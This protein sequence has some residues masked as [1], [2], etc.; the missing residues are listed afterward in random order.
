MTEPK[1]TKPKTTTRDK[2]RRPVK[3]ATLL[4]HIL[5]YTKANEITQGDTI[6]AMIDSLQDD[7]VQEAV[8]GATTG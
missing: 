1:T 5:E 3:P 7:I 6:Q 8:A 2:M 4:V